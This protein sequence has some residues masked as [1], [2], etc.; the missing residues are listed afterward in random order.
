MW[1]TRRN[2]I[3]TVICLVGCALLVLAE[4]TIPESYRGI[5]I[6]QIFLGTILAVGVLGGW[7]FSVGAT[8]LDLFAALFLFSPPYFARVLTNPVDLLR[9]LSFLFVGLVL[10]AICDSL[11]RAWNRI[12]ERQRRLEQE[13]HERCRAQMAERARADELMTTLASIGDGVIRT[14]ADGRVTFLNPVAEELVGWSTAEAAGRMLSDV[15]CIVHEVTRQPLQNPAALTLSQGHVVSLTNHTVLISRDGMERPIDDSAAP[16]RD[17]FGNIIGS[18]LV[19]RDI[20]E[21][22]RGQTA[23]REIER[24]YRAI[25]ES[26]DYGVWICDSAGRNVYASESFLRLVG[27]TQEEYFSFKWE[28]RLH[29]DDAAG[30][31]A[32]WND[33]VKRGGRW[34]H[35]HR[36]KGV[37]GNWYYVLSRGVPVT[38][39][40]GNVTS[41]V[42]INLDI[43][44]LKQVEA[45]LRNDDR[46]KDEFL[47][48]L[49][50]ELR[51]PLAP[52]VNSLEILKMPSVSPVL[53]RQAREI[54]ERQVHH[55]VRLVDDLLDVSRVMRGKIQLRCETVNLATIVARAVETVQPMIE[56]Q[57]HQLKLSL[58]RE[59][60]LLNADPVRLAQVLSNLLT[61]AAKYTE[62][63]GHI[64]LTVRREGQQAVLSVRDDGIG[65]ASDMLPEIFELFVQ[66]DHS[67]TRSQGGLGVGLTLV[68][69][70]VEMHGGSVEARSAGLGQGS[71]FI[72]CLPSVVESI[73][74][75]PVH[76]VPQMSDSESKLRLLVVDDNKDA[77]SSLAALL[78]LQGHDVRI[79]NCGAGALE[80]VVDFKPDLVM[81][82]IG[83]PEMDGYEVS[84]RMR[85]TPGLENTVLAALTGWGQVED[86]QRSADAGFDHHLMKPPE[87][88]ALEKLLSDVKRALSKT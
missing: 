85:K 25:G 53:A 45:E 33:C 54:V 23:L 66:A 61:N 80:T 68:K 47:A 48:T 52:I 87:P 72:V 42:G 84:R 15:F 74:A 1:R 10:C 34:D 88:T 86:R 22:Q 51:N 58:P 2:V 50:H 11:Q 67:S 64:Q 37:D 65:I 71:D 62:P 31:I 36:F 27:L 28:T 83:M 77:A 55:L 57:G 18:V 8:V 9:L 39:E 29:P 75:V 19:F 41:W 4:R 78:R 5:L 60:L 24:R 56:A 26:I 16:I 35:E 76:N 13:V 12:E 30:T 38:D 49:A 69:N 70:L 79:A 43:S 82:D 6:S 3:S 7:R 44:R 21:R 14:D 73:P 81:L 17:A 20:S 46:R 40:D 32:D 63:Q 59:N